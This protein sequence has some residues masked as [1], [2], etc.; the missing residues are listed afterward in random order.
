MQERHANH[1]Y[2][3]VEEAASRLEDSCIDSFISRR[4]SGGA[5]QDLRMSEVQQEMN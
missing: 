5:Y 4:G 3:E 2:F 1:P